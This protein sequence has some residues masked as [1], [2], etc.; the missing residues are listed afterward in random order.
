MVPVCNIFHV[1]INVPSEIFENILIDIIEKHTL[2][3]V[4]NKRIIKIIVLYGKHVNVMY[5]FTLLNRY[6]FL[7]WSNL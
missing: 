2:G 5:G 4:T 7:K 3:L 1:Y 6:P